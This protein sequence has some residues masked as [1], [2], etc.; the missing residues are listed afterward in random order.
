MTP[1]AALL[2]LAG[3]AAAAGCADQPVVTFPPARLLDRGAGQAVDPKAHET[4]V[5]VRVEDERGA[6]IAGAQVVVVAG[7]SYVIDMPGG[8]D[9]H[10][11]EDGIADGASDDA[12]LF[13]AKPRLSK[14]VKCLRAA[15][16]KGGLAGATER[17][18][19]RDDDGGAALIVVLRPG[20]TYSG[21]VVDS[22]GKPVPD[23]KVQCHFGDGDFDL[24]C[25][26]AGDGSFRLGPV[27]AGTGKTWIS[28][29]HHGP[30]REVWSQGETHPTPDRPIVLVVD[31]VPDTPENRK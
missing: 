21:R 19:E 18:F 16:V 9:G 5:T 6:T 20:V 7:W 10:V 4:P 31:P 23:A 25:G 1:R 24:E 3:V 14:N 17:K 29:V 26:V 30:L 22:A 27:P 2:V 8:G 28:A 11:G 15:A 13:V 12:G